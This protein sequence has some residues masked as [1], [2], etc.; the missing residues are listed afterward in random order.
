[1]T[2]DEI[3][4]RA[5]STRQYN[6]RYS[7]NRDGFDPLSAA[8]PTGTY[9]DGKPRGLD[10]G[11][12]V[13]WAAKLQL[14]SPEEAQQNQQS[15]QDRW[16]TTG[17]VW[18]ALGAQN[19]FSRLTAP[20]RGCLII[21]PDYSWTPKGISL[22]DGQMDVYAPL[23]DAASPAVNPEEP[24]TMRENMKKHDG[25]VGIVTSTVTKVQHCP[26]H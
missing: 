1:M 24:K 15:T 7:Q 8:P 5:R 17:I 20:Q 18:D 2:A 21:Y 6:V 4:D 14:L 16:D 3:I 10:C 26:K 12:F 22:T 9:T 11:T 23:A 19:R 25:H 13:Q